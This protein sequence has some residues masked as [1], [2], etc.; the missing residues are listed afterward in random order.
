[1]LLWLS[2]LAVLKAGGEST[3]HRVSPLWPLEREQVR[4]Q[5][6]EDLETSPEKH[7]SQLM[8][9]APFGKY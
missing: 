1:M 5:A 9:W 4:S 2:C 3:I 6:E 7:L 8:L